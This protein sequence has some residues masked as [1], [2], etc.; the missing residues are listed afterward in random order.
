M[1][2]EIELLKLISSAILSIRQIGEEARRLNWRIKIGKYRE[3]NWVDI[4]IYCNKAIIQM[5]NLRKML[6]KSR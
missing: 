6:K 2:N 5:E 1:E 3:R 4:D